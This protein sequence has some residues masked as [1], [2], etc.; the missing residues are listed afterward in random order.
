MYELDHQEN[1]VY[2]QFLET[3]RDNLYGHS[4]L[5]KVTIL[6]ESLQALSYF[7]V[8][9][10]PH[11]SL[12]WA[13]PSPPTKGVLRHTLATAVLALMLFVSCMP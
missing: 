5:G 12:Q 9:I 2:K 13:L 1:T 7:L 3:V 10:S 8:A 6:A 11:A 4:G